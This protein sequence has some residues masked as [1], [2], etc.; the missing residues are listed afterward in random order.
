MKKDS[1]TEL[2]KEAKAKMRTK[3]SSPTKD[4]NIKNMNIS[5]IQKILKNGGIGVFPTDTIYGLIGSALSKKAVRRIYKLRR[6]SFKK[7]MIILIG[8]LIDLNIFNIKLDKRLKKILN[9]IWPGP[10]SIIL[11]CPDKKFFYL[12]RGIKTLAFRLPAK[13]NLIKLLKKTGPLVAPSAN[14][15][16]IPP[17]KNIK[18]A[19]KDFGEKVDFYFNEGEKAGKP[20]VI[21]E[22]KR[23]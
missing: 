15:E 14:L 3:S 12:H 23:K 17:A 20:S 6:R 7:P 13:T 11:P 8:S 9:K 18:E 21:L 22:I 16:G 1:K 10:V 5:G 4:V 19:K 2:P